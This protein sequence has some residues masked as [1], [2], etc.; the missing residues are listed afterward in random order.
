MQGIGYGLMEGMAIESG[1]VSALSLADYKIP[2]I[3]DVPA[4]QAIAI[5]SDGG[6]GP[7]NI[8]G[9]GEN[10]VSPAAAAIANAIEDAVGVRAGDLPI[11]AERLLLLLRADS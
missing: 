6:V 11:T 9:I 7:F 10:P 3:A 2:N 5:E 1:D 4:M 8:K